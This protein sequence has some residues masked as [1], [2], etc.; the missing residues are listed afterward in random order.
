MGELLAQTF[1][2]GPTRFLVATRQQDQEFFPAVAANG[3]ILADRVLHAA[4]G[5]TE[6]GVPGK[7][8]VVVIDVLEMVEIHHHYANRSTFPLPAS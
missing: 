3:I 5:F 8:A 7:V 4:R 1:R 2:L 6:N